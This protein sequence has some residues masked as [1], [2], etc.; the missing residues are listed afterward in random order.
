M[1]LDTGNV[2]TEHFY[3]DF[4]QTSSVSMVLT[5]FYTNLLPYMPRVPA[6]HRR[7]KA[8]VLD[9]WFLTKIYISN[10]QSHRQKISCHICFPRPVGRIFLWHDLWRELFLNIPRFI[11]RLKSSSLYSLWRKVITF[12]VR[13][14]VSRVYN[15]AWNPSKFWIKSNKKQSTQKEYLKGLYFAFKC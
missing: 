13:N 12:S 3:L 1:S 14:L 10:T 5:S 7:H 15:W 9:F 11:Q 8:Q 4:G 2:F 6:V